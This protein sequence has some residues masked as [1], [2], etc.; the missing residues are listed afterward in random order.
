MGSKKKTDITPNIEV[1]G[2]KATD[3]VGL[4]EAAKSP[5]AKLIARAFSDAVFRPLGVFFEGKAEASRMKSLARARLQVAKVGAD[6][7][8]VLERMK[9]R[10]LSQEL[11]RELN[12]EETV[13]LALEYANEAE[14]AEGGDHPSQ[15]EIPQAWFLRWSEGAQQADEADIRK[16]W[17]RLLANRAQGESENFR[18]STVAL[19]ADMDGHVAD[20]FL[21]FVCVLVQAKCVCTEIDSSHYGLKMADLALLR[22]FGL[23]DNYRP[24]DYDFGWVRVLPSV[25]SFVA[26]LQYVYSAAT[27]TQRGAAL[28]RALFGSQELSNLYPERFRDRLETERIVATLVAHVAKRYGPVTVVFSD[29]DLA[30]ERSKWV[31]DSRIAGGESRW[32]PQLSKLK[33]ED[34]RQRTLLSHLE[35]LLSARDDYLYPAKSP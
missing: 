23:L 6:T 7:A 11:R 16:L 20:L 35:P 30:S 21:T 17:A 32:K 3:I 22:E 28:A 14:P 27:L 29:A 34:E 10:F 2:A 25:G 5:A 1:T 26:E 15:E 13:A 31:F 12:L 9:G 4:G 33:P 24:K 18:P 8:D 19:L